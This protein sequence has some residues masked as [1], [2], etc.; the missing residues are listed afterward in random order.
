MIVRRDE[1]GIY[2]KNARGEPY[3][4]GEI[5]GF[6]HV[7]AMDDGGLKEG[8]NPKT[9]HQNQSPLLRIKL[10]DGRI[11]YWGPEDMLDKN[12]TPPREGGWRPP[13]RELYGVRVFRDPE[14]GEVNQ[15]PI[16]PHIRNRNRNEEP[17][18]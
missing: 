8:D 17:D 2:I 10:D 12:K 5:A 14:T 13:V 7:Y 15:I 1:K 9:I 4:P 18:F 11:L 6:S 3:R 16:I